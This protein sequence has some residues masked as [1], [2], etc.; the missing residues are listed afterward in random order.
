MGH[1]SESNEAELSSGM[2]VE[3]MSSEH[4]WMAE[5]CSGAVEEEEAMGSKHG[6]DG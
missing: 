3:D 4:G 1:D 5:L 6:L 2:G